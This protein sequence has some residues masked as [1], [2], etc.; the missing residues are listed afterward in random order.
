MRGCFDNFT[1]NCF[2]K[3]YFNIF[4]N[5]NKLFLLLLLWEYCLNYPIS[6]SIELILSKPLNDSVK[7][8]SVVPHS[9]AVS[10]VHKRNFPYQQILWDRKILSDWNRIAQFEPMISLLHFLTKVKHGTVINNVKPKKDFEYISELFEL[11]PSIGK[12]NLIP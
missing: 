1:C 5:L 3:S 12:I 7:L 2:S 8:C 4:F 10:N 6:L 9:V 11:P